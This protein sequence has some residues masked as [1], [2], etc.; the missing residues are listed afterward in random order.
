MIEREEYV[1]TLRTLGNS[2]LYEETTRMVYLSSI[3][4]DE[5]E[6]SCHWKVDLIF[7]EWVDRDLVS[8]YE[9]AHAEVSGK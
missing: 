6:E 7:V 1:R 2:E 9:R 8:E 4:Y 5:G 3:R